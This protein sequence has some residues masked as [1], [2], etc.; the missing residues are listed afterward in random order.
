M[1]YVREFAYLP[2][3][4][5]DLSEEP[6]NLGKHLDYSAARYQHHSLLIPVKKILH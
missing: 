6:G 2:D 1:D 4:L 3:E 5:E